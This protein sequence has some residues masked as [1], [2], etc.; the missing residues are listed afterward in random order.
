MHKILLEFGHMYTN[1]NRF[2]FI[3]EQGSFFDFFRCFEEKR[4]FLILAPY[5]IV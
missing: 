2:F 1:K 3:L 5:L 4:I